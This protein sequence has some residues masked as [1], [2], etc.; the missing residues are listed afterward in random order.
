MCF[1]RDCLQFIKYYL[2]IA[3]RRLCP[4]FI[5]SDK[6]GVELHAQR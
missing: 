2:L 4:P 1:L 5:L 6:R 3:N